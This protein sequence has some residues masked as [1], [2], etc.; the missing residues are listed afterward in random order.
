ML[1][2]QIRLKAVFLDISP[3]SD[4]LFTMCPNLASVDA[5]QTYKVINLRINL[6]SIDIDLIND[7]LRVN[8]VFWLDIT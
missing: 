4:D 7:I 5:K 8:T 6:V 3:C 1:W 2:F